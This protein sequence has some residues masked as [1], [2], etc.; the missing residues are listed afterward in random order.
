MDTS[1][2]AMLHKNDPARKTYD[3]F[4]EQFGLSETIIITVTPPNIF[5]AD[6]LARLSE[7]HSV[8]ENE[9]PFVRRVTS[10][11][12]VRNMRTEDDFLLVEDLL[13]NIPQTP[14]EMEEFAR[15]VFANP[16]YANH[17]ISEDGRHAALMLE[18][19]ALVAK[20]GTQGFLESFDAVEAPGAQP[21]QTTA[22]FGE[23][24]NRLLVDALN[25]IIARHNAPDFVVTLSGGPVVVDAFNR[26]TLA[27]MRLC[28]TLAI[29]INIFFLSVLFRRFT[30][31]LF[32]L[33]IVNSATASTIGLMALLGVS[34]KMTT[35]IIPPFLLAVGVAASVHV[36]AI[37]FRRFDAGESKEDSIAYALGHSGFAIALTSLTT[38]AGLLSFSFAEL[39][40]IGEVGR[41]AAMGVL[42]AFFY[43]VILLPALLAVI[44][45]RPKT[46]KFS[47]P[48]LMDRVLL[49]FADFSIARY[50]SIVTI[51]VL[52]TILSVS[53]L[54]QLRFSNNI[55]DY[56]AETM[57]VK[58]N[59]LMMD[60]AMNGV[61]TLEALVDTKTPNGL[62][63][64][65][66]MRRM[67][68]AS[69]TLM[70]HS[71]RDIFVGKVFSVVDILKEIH[72][73]LNDNDPDF[74]RIPPDRQAI[75]QEFLLFE[76]SGSTDLEQ[77]VDRDFS[78]ARMIVKIPWVDS[79]VL[80]DFVDW[81]TPM[82]ER[83]FA[84]KASV[85]LTGIAAIMARTIPATLE[86]MTES[87]VIAFVTI[88][89][90]ML[91]LLWNVRIGLVAMFPNLLPIAMVMGIIGMLDIPLNLNTI[92]IGSIAIGL[93]VDDTM[94]F[95]YNYCKYLEYT[96][97]SDRSIRETMLGTGRAILITSMVLGS[98]FFILL[99]ASLKNFMV[100]GF[101]T[102][103]IIL[104]ALAADLLLAPALMTLMHHKKYPPKTLPA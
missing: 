77:Y 8:L 68:E 85:T 1:S 27:D 24:E 7:F 83:T 6:F 98:G 75:A 26:A 35:T 22:Y 37:F 2:E 53:G 30:G 91:F 32:P 13:E 23:K 41:F 96:G 99:F 19:E 16:L 62:H 60:K 81:A 57:P 86:S 17:I 76:S 52:L 78:K 69:Q 55:V 56:F 36:L 70:A 50:K 93:V 61:V 80:E 29:F 48:G 43:T 20:P 72:Q 51:S 104:V 58:Q 44:P 45:L 42:L 97:D 73:S 87:Y 102:G 39:A 59:L 46:P 3:A 103:I 88:T 84:E 74:Y 82:L 63:E 90:M 94:H 33:L 101:F 95:M 89:L 40:A 66:M 21:G 10:L 65:D 15:Q 49:S 34:L 25:D 12:N 67:E 64:P 11:V 92:M 18:A 71:S 38:A 28:I 31:V 4:K 9:A 5:D 47:G 54:V 79:V 14:Q 100:F